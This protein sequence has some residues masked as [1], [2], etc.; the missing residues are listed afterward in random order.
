MARR[1]RA[2][3]FLWLFA[4]LAGFLTPEAGAQTATEEVWSTTMTLGAL[5]H[6]DFFGY[7]HSSSSGHGRS[8]YDGL[9]ADDDFDIS[10][11]IYTVWQLYVETPAG[12]L[13]FMVATGST[14]AATALP[15]ADEF[16][17]QLQSKADP[18]DFST[19][20]YALTDATWDATNSRYRWDGLYRSGFLSGQAAAE[21]LTV[22]LVRT[23]TTDTTAPTVTITE[24]PA[25]SMAA[26]TATFTFSEVVTGF[27]VGDIVV[28]NGTASAFMETTAGTVFTALITP[29]AAGTVTVDVAAGVAVDEADNGN[30]AAAQATSIYS[31]TDPCASSVT[32]QVWCGAV[33]VNSVI[34]ATE[35]FGYIAAAHPVSASFGSLSDDDFEVDGTTYTVWRVTYDTNR[36]E[37]DWTF[38][39][40]TGGTLTEFPAANLN[41]LSVRFSDK[42]DPA[43]TATAEL[44]AATYGANYGYNWLP[45]AKPSGFDNWKIGDTAAV[46]L[47][48]TVAA[49][50]TAPRVT[51]AERQDPGSSPTNAD[52]LKWRITFSEDVE[53]VGIADFAVSGTTAT[54]TAVT[55]VMA[56]TVYDVTASDGDLAGLDATVT[57]SF[58]SGQDIADTAG[59]ALSN[60]APTGTNDN[61]YVVDNTAPM[62]DIT[63]VPATSTAPFTATFGF[64]EGVY[65]YAVGDITVTNAT[66]S[67]FTGQDGGTVFTALITPTADGMVT[68]DV[69]AG[70]ARDA[71]GNGNTAAAQATSTYTA[72]IVDTTAPRVTSVE[73]QDPGSSRTNADSLKWRIT[74]DED[75]A[76]VGTADFAVSGTTATVTDVTEVTA[77]TVYDVT[78]S[79]GDLAGLDATVTLSF[80]SGQDIADTAGNA[81]SNTAPTGTNDNTYVVDNTA[82]TVAITGVPATST[83][84]FTATFTFSEGVNGFAVGDIA[85][86]NGA[87]SAFTGQ[88]GDPVFTA[89]ITPAA[90]GMVTVDV[91]A[92][93]AR[94]AAGNGNPA[95]AQATSTYT[96]PLVDANAPRVTLVERQDP[97]SSPTNA[98][99]LK[100]R[101]T[102]SENVENV[103][104]A[105]FAVSGTTA[106]VTAVTEMTA[107]TVYDV[108][109]SGGTW[110]VWMPR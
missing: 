35:G 36:A 8:V 43:T 100:W 5:G 48:R 89:M 93:A 88:P 70:V 51:S 12:R 9:L 18:T 77:S 90:T 40:A 59:N 53:N 74:F 47:I 6:S 65:G 106:T 109:V 28:G 73:R 94:D 68:V 86:G 25:T 56:S 97:G 102:F 104:T 50:T 32:G 31:V 52:S 3:A 82:P 61:T 21:T 85:V 95:A 72:P 96:A 75:V 14:K 108:T 16:T 13:Y 7:I 20:S 37:F 76:N 69:A 55:E 80:A 22:K 63:G 78:V 23:T 54:V 2:A 71:A 19:Y 57:L 41:E 34:A 103:G 91:A 79:G 42:D 64:S 60:T 29:A 92:S 101:I 26:F 83:A 24:V 49:D 45:L 107:S 98:D 33:A 87:A 110:R 4:A 81:L 66:V 46:R 17:L 27:A 1:L 15:D 44:S 99:S 105:D 30:T 62:M 10:G 84:M 38:A 67:A 58:A 39:V 11:T